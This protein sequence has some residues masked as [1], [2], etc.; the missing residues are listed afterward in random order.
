MPSAR[1]EVGQD[2]S[3][4][5][6]EV[7]NRQIAELKKKIQLSGILVLEQNGMLKYPIHYYNAILLLYQFSK[8]GNQNF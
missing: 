4:S 5:I 8:V 6:L 7:V 2:D 1:S 3:E